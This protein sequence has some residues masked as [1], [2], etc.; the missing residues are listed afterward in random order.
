MKISIQDILDHGGIP[1][2]IEAIASEHDSI[3][4]GVIGPSFATSG[5]GPG[6]SQDFGCNDYAARALADDYGAC[7]YIDSADGREATLDEADDVV[8][9][10]ESVVELIAPSESQIDAHRS[11][12]E[13]MIAALDAGHCIEGRGD[14]DDVRALIEANA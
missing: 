1:S 7:S 9:S 6:W 14:W 4:S 5:P 10:D 8:W 3:A 13:M 11:T 2:A 12:V